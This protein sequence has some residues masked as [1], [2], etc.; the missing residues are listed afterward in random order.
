MADLLPEEKILIDE[1]W[2]VRDDW[3]LRNLIRPVNGDSDVFWKEGT[4]KGE[5][6]PVLGTNLMTDYLFPLS[7]NP[8][9]IRHLYN[10][11]RRVELKTLI[12]KNRDGVNARR[13]MQKVIVHCTKNCFG[14]GCLSGSSWIYIR[15]ELDQGIR[16]ELD[17][18]PAGAG[19][20]SFF[21]TRYYHYEKHKKLCSR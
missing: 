3:S 9:R 20:F 2:E 15:I 18:Y 6:A 21:F 14:S 17:I 7:V 11:N 1:M 8:G 13:K 19:K 12:A 4:W 10:T 5:L 16:L